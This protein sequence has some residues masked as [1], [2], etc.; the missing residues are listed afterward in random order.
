MQSIVS[1]KRNAHKEMETEAWQISAPCTVD[2][3]SKGGQN[4]SHCKARSHAGLV[5]LPALVTP[6]LMACARLAVL[7]YAEAYM[8]ATLHVSE[9]LIC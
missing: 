8:T 9:D 3:D 2:A 7:P 5:D 4:K 6:L 1:R